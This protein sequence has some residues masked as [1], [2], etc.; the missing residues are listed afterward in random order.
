MR[1][2]VD[3]GTELKQESYENATMVH[4]SGDVGTVVPV[5]GQR[6]KIQGGALV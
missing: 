2:D 4:R 6:R 3:F 1:M 5:S